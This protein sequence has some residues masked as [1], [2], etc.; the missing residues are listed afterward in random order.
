MFAPLRVAQKNL[1]RAA[2]IAFFL[3]GGGYL[4]ETYKIYIER[5]TQ[6]PTIISQSST[7]SIRVEQSS[8]HAEEGRR[9]WKIDL[10][11]EINLLMVYVSMGKGVFH[12]PPP[13]PPI[14]DEKL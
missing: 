2:E 1:T 5:G 10:Y 8:K 14:L 13:T 6:T 9:W 7:S 4:R 11:E 12:P 3:G